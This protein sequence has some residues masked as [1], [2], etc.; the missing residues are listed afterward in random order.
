MF[1]LGLGELLV[2]LV[3]LVL[4]FGA[5]RLPQLGQGLGDGLRSFRRAFREGRSDDPGRAKRDG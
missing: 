3:I 4:F 5:N 1:G 2:I